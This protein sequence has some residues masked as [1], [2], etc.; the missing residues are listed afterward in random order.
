MSRKVKPLRIEVVGSHAVGKSALVK[1]I[2]AVYGLPVLDEIARIEIA[3]MGGGFDKLRTDLDAVTRF[4]K[5]VFASQLQV[6]QGVARYVSDRAFDN[7]AYA[8]ENAACGTAA[9]MW[10]S[11][12]CRRYVRGIAD[13]VR[14]CEGAVFFV[15]PGVPLAHDGVRAEGDLNAAGVLLI[16][17]MVKLLLELGDVPYVPIRTTNFQERAAIVA[18]VLRGLL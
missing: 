6:G 2:A 1:H 8:A 13:T 12:A 7:I 18:G 11:P 17:G 16:D 14:R 3:K 5:N 10:R 4:Q 9:A 15:R